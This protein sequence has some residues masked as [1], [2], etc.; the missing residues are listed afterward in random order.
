M[1]EQLRQMS[2]QPAVHCTEV[3]LDTILYIV[4]LTLSKLDCR[5]HRV[6]CR[7][8]AL[9]YTRDGK[10]YK[11]AINACV[12]N[13]LARVKYVRNFTLFCRESELCC[14]FALLGVIFM[15]FNL[16]NF[17]FYFKKRNK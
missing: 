3:I 12:K 1:Q 10:T 15:A 17:Y 9:H 6:Y 8:Y 2:V 11:R 16:V 7:L 4:Q 13:F 5:D 14:D